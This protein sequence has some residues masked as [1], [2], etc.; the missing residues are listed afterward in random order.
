MHERTATLKSESD[1][2]VNKKT[3]DLNLSEQPQVGVM[4]FTHTSGS[5]PLE[6]YTIKRGIGVGGFGEVYF[7]VSDT[8]K[9]VA[10]K[11]IQRNRDVELRG[12]SQCLNLKHP[13]LVSL[14]NIRYDEQESGWV[15]MEY[16]TGES[17]KDVIESHPQ[18]MPDEL[19]RSWISGIAAGT[20]YLHDHGIVHRDLKP[21][22]IFLDEG[23]VKIGD[24]GL[25]KF[26]SVSR[27]SGQTE[28]VGTFHYMAPE[29]GKGSYGKEI[30][31]YALGVVLYEMLTGDV[32]FDGETG[33]EIIMKH[34]TDA[35]DLS[36]LSAPYREVVAKALSKDPAN[37][38]STV[39][40]MVAPLGI[41]LSK[42]Q[43][44]PSIQHVK[45]RDAFPIVDEGQERETIAETVRLG[46]S[47][48]AKAVLVP[49]EESVGNAVGYRR[50][51]NRGESPSKFSAPLKVILVVVVVA[52]FVSNSPLLLFLSIMSGLCYLGYLE[53][54]ALMP[55]SAPDTR[56]PA[57]PGGGN[58]EAAPTKTRRVRRKR[59]LSW[60]ELG[61][62][63]LREKTLQ[64]RT[65]ELVGSLLM[66]ALVMVVL[67][68]VSLILGV[69]MG[70]YD[71]TGSVPIWASTYAWITCSSLIGA[72]TVLIAHKFWEGRKPDAALRR[73]AMLVMGLGVG[74]VSFGLSNWLLVE[75]TYLISGLS[76]ISGSY[77]SSVYAPDGSPQLLAYLGY[78]AGL[79]VV[80][81][82]WKGA[83]PM[84]TTRLS[85]WRTAGAVFWAL[86][87]HLFFP[88]PRGLLITGMIAIAVQLAAPWIDSSE[89]A[90]IRESQ[91]SY[92]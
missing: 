12:V 61:Y 8:G 39:G 2:I 43:P 36:P 52:F 23:L 32:P 68:V 79:F 4:K 20:A 38:Y 83:D 87:L 6:G 11:H 15:V 27:R 63:V 51:G 25:S 84:R 40:Q 75:P 53:V 54:R 44:V 69:V 65:V 72:W 17:L 70:N 18:G 88:F 47:T 35:P 92:V 9:E 64:Q 82:F 55:S 80:L 60:Q 67:G 91:R 21:G 3:V 24:Y 77:P 10:L 85:F 59:Y 28:S 81:R 78:F 46:V 13:N 29:I 50:K 90:R 1:L 30:D 22:N 42:T 48:S 76:E 58:H 66:S 74:A 45:A 71:L 86:L 5:R 26:I 89:R 41:E 49:S 57:A 62:Q 56:S 14:F 34:L 31:V 7:A 37:R 33:Q 19:V 73:F 16:V